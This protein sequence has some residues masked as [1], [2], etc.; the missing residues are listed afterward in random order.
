MMVQPWVAE[1]M[2]EEHRRQLQGR[3][4]QRT[5]LSAHVLADLSAP[6]A[7]RSMAGG[8]AWVAPELDR[9]ADLRGQV[10]SWLIRAGTRLGGASI[11]PS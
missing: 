4:R 3:P 5:E 9:Y 10:G 11:S 7:P 6:E 8:A 1:R 2:T